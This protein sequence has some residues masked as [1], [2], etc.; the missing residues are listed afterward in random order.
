MSSADKGDSWNINSLDEDLFLTAV[1]FLD[2]D[3]GFAVGEF[4]SVYKTTDGGGY[5]EYQEP[6]PNEFYPQDAYFADAERGWVVGLSGAV[7]HTADGG[8]NW[9]LQPSDTEAPLYSIAAVAGDLYAVG[10]Y[11]TLMRLEGEH[12]KRVE[13]GKPVRFYLRAIEQAAPGQLLIAGGFGALHS[14][15]L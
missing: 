5:W 1:Q 15:D 13:H 7:M 8:K 2:A 14:V 3:T 4:G 12:W 11:G 9:A 10:G 6:L